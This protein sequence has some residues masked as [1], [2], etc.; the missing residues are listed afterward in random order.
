LGS[1][2]ERASRTREDLKK[3]EAGVVVLERQP[4]DLADAVTGSITMLEE[5]G[6]FKA[7]TLSVD[8]ESLMVTGI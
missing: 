7:H 3:I 2:D 6:R 1:S 4:C 8:A 5:A